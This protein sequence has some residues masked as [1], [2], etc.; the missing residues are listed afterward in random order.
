MK[1]II[2]LLAL[3]SLATYFFGQDTVHVDCREFMYIDQN[4]IKQ[5][6]LECVEFAYINDTCCVNPILK[7]CDSL[8][9]LV[10]WKSNIKKLPEYLIDKIT[11]VTLSNLEV[12]P[13]NLHQFNLKKINIINCG[14]DLKGIN[15]VFD[16]ND[17]GYVSIYHTFNLDIKKIK[18][19]YLDLRLVDST[20]HK[21]DS[22]Y[23]ENCE[24]IFMLQSY[25]KALERC[26][27]NSK[28]KKIEFA[29]CTQVFLDEKFYRRFTGNRT[30][31]KIDYPSLLP[32]SK[33]IKLP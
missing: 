12:V 18:T 20:W 28:L 19:K 16:K 22:V 9:G 33:I 7:Q 25:P 23:I 17:F 15:K 27:F 2:S 11:N 4:E 1:K 8:I 21:T 13:K 5:E 24:E 6:Y 30:K 32:I 14:D 3:F 31:I 29:V 10:I 26:N